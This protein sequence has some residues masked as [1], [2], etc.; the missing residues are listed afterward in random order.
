MEATD[1]IARFNQLTRKSS[2]FLCDHGGM[3]CLLMCVL[4]VYRVYRVCT[5]WHGL[6]ID[7]RTRCIP[8][9][10]CMHQVA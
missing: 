5:R 6:L 10:P 9:I 1:A 7:V 2:G 4:A 8:C 3:V